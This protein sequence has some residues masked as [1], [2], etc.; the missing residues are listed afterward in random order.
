MITRLETSDPLIPI[1]SE[2]LAHMSRFFTIKHYDA[3]I[4]GALKN[5]HR[6]VLEEERQAYMIQESG[7]VIGLALI[8]QHLR[9]TSQ[10]FAV[11]E[12]FI[13]KPHEKKGHGRRLAEHLFKTLP[14]PWEVAVTS[15]N[16]KALKFWEKVVTAFTL[17][18]FKQENKAGLTGFIF[19]TAP[20]V[21]HLHCLSSSESACMV[22]TRFRSP[23]KGLHPSLPLV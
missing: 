15:T 1:Y 19:D 16:H 11:A 7:T 14:G 17:G 21:R 23:G 6:C 12:F 8:N 9:F 22:S 18:Q 5:L 3:W 10:G 20:K 2:Y 13:Q 4:E